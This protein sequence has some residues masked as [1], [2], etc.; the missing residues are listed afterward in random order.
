MLNVPRVL[1]RAE[2][3]QH[4]LCREMDPEFFFPQRGEDSD[5]AKAVCA[6]CPVQSECRDY[7][8][9]MGEKHGIWGGLSERQRQPIRRQLNGQIRECLGCG[10]PF[11]IGPYSGTKT[12]SDECGSAWERHLYRVEEVRGSLPEGTVNGSCG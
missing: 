9:D 5:A 6:G 10:R 12:C 2:W 8:L 7:A 4:G 1:I 11:R 3:Q